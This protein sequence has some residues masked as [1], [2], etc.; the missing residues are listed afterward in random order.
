MRIRALLVLLVGAIVLLETPVGALPESE[1]TVGNGFLND[2]VEVRAHQNGAEGTEGSQPM[3]N[4]SPNKVGTPIDLS[5]INCD[6]SAASWQRVQ[7]CSVATPRLTTPQAQPPATPGGPQQRALDYF[8]SLQM[9]VPQ[10]TISAPQG[11]CGVEH[12]LDLHI[13]ARQ[14]FHEPNTPFGP[15]TLEVFGQFVVDWGDGTKD[16]YTTTGAPWPRSDIDHSWTNRGIYN[17]SV[18]ANWRANWSYGGS[19]GTVSGLTTTG[20]ISNWRVIELQ[21]VIIDN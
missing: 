4:A 14:S 13:P 17:I 3:G 18:T 8:N 9:P 21:A 2:T 11:I 12:S 20:A 5:S 10:P 16:T 1:T 15:L 6:T 19:S 7:A